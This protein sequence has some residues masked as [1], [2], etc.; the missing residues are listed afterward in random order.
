V[1]VEIAVVVR[2]AD[3]LRVLLQGVAGLHGAGEV[4]HEP[5]EGVG[6]VGV[7]G[8]APVGLGEVGVDGVLD[9]QVGGLLLA[10]GAALLAVDHEALGHLVQ[11]RLHEHALH[12]VLHMLLAGH[13]HPFQLL[14]DLAGHALGQD[15]ILDAA[16]LQGLEDGL[17]DALQGPGFQAAVA[18]LYLKGHEISLT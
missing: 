8:H 17:G 1:D 9:V 13:V 4:Q 14:L 10:Q 3:F 16:G 6:H 12:H 7:L 2:G 15:G 18:F 11:A 5:L